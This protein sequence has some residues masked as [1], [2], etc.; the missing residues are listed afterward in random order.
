MQGILFQI[1]P[2]DWRTDYYD[3]EHMSIW[4]SV[5]LSKDIAARMAEIHSSENHKGQ[6]GYE[7]WDENWKLFSERYSEVLEK[8][9]NDRTMS[10]EIQ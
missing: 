7:K 1:L 3:N 8:A 10:A 5:K 2:I 6:A 4:G 9:E